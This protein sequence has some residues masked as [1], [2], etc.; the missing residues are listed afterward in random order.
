MES[1][2]SIMAKGDALFVSLLLF[3]ISKTSTTQ[4]K[5]L[6]PT[7]QDTGEFHISVHLKVGGLEHT[8]EVELGEQWRWYL[9]SWSTSHGNWTCSPRK[10]SSDRGGSEYNSGLLAAVV[11]TATDNWAAVAVGS[12][13][14]SLQLWRCPWLSSLAPCLQW[15]SP[16]TWQ[17]WTEQRFLCHLSYLPSCS[18][19]ACNSGGPKHGR[20]VHH[21]GVPG[22]DTSHTSSSMAP[23]TL[24]A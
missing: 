14:L 15:Q 5:C 19:S 8:E 20:I 1:D 17:Y 2:I 11:P 10:P 7:H 4:Q 23:T 24:E 22:S 18:G 12:G 6:C 9:Q 21:P 16:Q 3:T 13:T